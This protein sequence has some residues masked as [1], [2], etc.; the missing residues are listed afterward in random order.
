MI[1]VGNIPYTIKCNNKAIH[2]WHSGVALCRSAA[3][4]ELS[5]VLNL[6]TPGRLSACLSPAPETLGV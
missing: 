4:V 5:V 3:P 1:D 6:R 2:S